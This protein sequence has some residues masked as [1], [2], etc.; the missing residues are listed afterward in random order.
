MDA[1]QK[2]LLLRDLSL[3]AMGLAAVFVG[4]MFYAVMRP[5]PHIFLISGLFTAPFAGMPS[6]P[7]IN[8]FPSFVHTLAFVLMS[9]GALGCRRISCAVKIAAAWVFIELIFEIGQHAAVKKLFV[10]ELPAC[11][12]KVPVLDRTA[13]FF[14]HGRY[15]T[16]DVAAI[17]IAA[18]LALALIHWL[19]NKGESHANT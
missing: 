14:L 10:T 13:A 9:A 15:D 1:R 4:T 16:L 6:V 18:A 17:F 11:L 19:E 2:T 8:A 7:G 3:I 5:T 12:E